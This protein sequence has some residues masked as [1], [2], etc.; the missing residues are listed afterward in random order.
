MSD[1]S[2]GIKL[3]GFQILSPKEETRSTTPALT[4]PQ[5]DDGAVVLET[6]A[7]YARGVDMDLS[8]RNEIELITRY[9]ELAQ[10]PELELAIENITN[11]AIT[12][13]DDGNVVK[14]NLDKTKFPESV[15][16]KIITEFDVIQNLLN[17]RLQGHDIFR[18]WYI[19]GRLPYNI[20]VD[21]KKRA[22]GIQELRYMDPRRVRKI[23]EITREKDR[24]SGHEVIKSIREYYL[25]NEMGV[26]GLSSHQQTGAVVVAKDSIA[27]VTSGLQDAR[28]AMVLSYIQKSI[29][30]M[31]QLRMMEDATV[32]YKVSRAVDRRVFYVD[33]GNLPR[34]KAEQYLRDMMTKYKNKIIYDSGTGEIQGDRKFMSMQEDFWM[35][36][37]GETGKGTEIDTLPG[38]ESLA[39]MDNVLYF[40]K[41]LYQS[42]GVP[43]GRLLPTDGFSLGRSNEITR[44]E[45]AFFKLIA[46][47]R[48]R[49]SHLFS[50]ILGIQLSLKG[51]CSKDDWET[52]LQNVQYDWM[53][54]TNFEE[55]K[56]AELMTMRFQLLAI[57]EPFIG[58]F[59]SGETAQKK[60][61]RMTDEQIAEETKRITAETE[62]QSVMLPATHPMSPM[63]QDPNAGEDP[64]KPEDAEPNADQMTGD[65]LTPGEN[66]ADTAF[67]HLQ[68]NE[69]VKPRKSLNIIREI[70]TNRRKRL[71][72]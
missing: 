43:L 18:R 41:K 57:V 51:I 3:W 68:A 14:L 28:R 42:L 70:M 1:L 32:V 53:K 58:R 29:K 59:M 22:E 10:Q 2:H 16:K 44:E 39:N 33:V 37:R 47:L 26:L 13:D 25:Y 40:Q 71:S 36:R 49:F 67:K 61:L 30:P 34:T 4:A 52:Q 31:N 50:V 35:P 11:E 56:N 55:L 17:F 66:D 64:E 54:D 8:A 60:I 9:R 46:R 48:N 6:G 24:A 69:G 12:E 65:V 23:R 27:Y 63:Y 21:E 20:L 62:K 7:A 5:N 19:D 72:K 38:G 45:L 15:K